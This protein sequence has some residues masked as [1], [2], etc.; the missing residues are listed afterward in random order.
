MGSRYLLFLSIKFC[1]SSKDFLPT[2]FFA[3][4]SP[5]LS[6]I[7]NK[8]LVEQKLANKQTI[9]LVSGPNNT[10]PVIINAVFNNGIK[11]NSVK[12]VVS[13]KK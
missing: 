8:K 11:H 4:P 6:P 5:Y 7:K 10:M 12:R 3:K 2:N 9:N 13:I 1:A